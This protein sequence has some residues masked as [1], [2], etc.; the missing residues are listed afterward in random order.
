M[1]YGERVRP[2]IYPVPD[3]E[4]GQKCVGKVTRNCIVGFTN[5]SFVVLRMIGPRAGENDSVRT[6]DE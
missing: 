4:E 6:V 1:T 5:T 3:R 2:C